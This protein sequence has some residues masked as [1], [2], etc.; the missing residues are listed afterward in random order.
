MATR[1]VL[2]LF[3]NLQIQVENFMHKFVFILL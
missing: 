2:A 3:Q 1:F